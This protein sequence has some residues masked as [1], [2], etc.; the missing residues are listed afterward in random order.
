MDLLF[1]FLANNLELLRENCIY[2]CHNTHIY[3]SH[4]KHIYTINI[5]IHYILYIY[6]GRGYSTYLRIQF[7]IVHDV[8]IS[9]PIVRIPNIV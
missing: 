3:Y 8:D 1:H 2:Y 9:I 7:S 4:N 5:N 6:V